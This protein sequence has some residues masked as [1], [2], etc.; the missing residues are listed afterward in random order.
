M[1]KYE[2][3]LDICFLIPMY[4]VNALLLPL[5]SIYL[6]IHLLTLYL[7]FYLLFIYNISEG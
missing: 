3:N 4:F 2:T 7:S 1:Q 6:A 5:I